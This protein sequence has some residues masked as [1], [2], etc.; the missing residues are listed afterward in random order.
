MR[1]LVVAL[2]VAWLMVPVAPVRAQGAGES[3]AGEQEVDDSPQGE[4]GTAD[5][6]EDSETEAES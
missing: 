1:Q 3:P 4:S 6:S 5:D 2:G